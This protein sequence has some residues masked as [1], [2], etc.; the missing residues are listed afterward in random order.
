[1][2][3]LRRIS[4]LEAKR[5]EASETYESF[6]QAVSAL[7]ASGPTAVYYAVDRRDYL[8]QLKSTYEKKRDK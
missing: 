5:I 7:V 1:M 8:K 3:R 2:S 6:E 4:Y